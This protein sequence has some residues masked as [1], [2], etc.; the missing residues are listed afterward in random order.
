MK[1]HRGLYLGINKN[2]KPFKTDKL[3][4]AVPI[5]TASIV[6][7]LAITTPVNAATTDPNSTE[8]ESSETDT[9]NQV[10]D[11]SSMNAN[12]S[13]NA[14]ENTDDTSATPEDN[15]QTPITP[16]TTTLPTP[17]IHTNNQSDA[18][19]YAS[20]AAPKN[21]NIGSETTP[22][23]NAQDT[24]SQTPT[25]KPIDSIPPLGN[26]YV[27][28]SSQNKYVPYDS[29]GYASVL[30]YSSEHW[31]DS[32]NYNPNQELYSFYIVLPTGVTSTVADM[33][34]G[35]DQ[36]VKDLAARGYIQISSLTAFQLNNT[37]VETGNRE[38][39]YFRPDDNAH[40]LGTVD[41]SKGFIGQTKMS[42]KIHTPAADT[43]ITGVNIN[44]LED[45]GTTI[46]PSGSVPYNDVLY[47][48]IGDGTYDI[49]NGYTNI[50]SSYFGS[51]WLDKNVAGISVHN[52]A[53]HLDYTDLNVNDLYTVFT[54]GTAGDKETVIY[55][56][57]S[58]LNTGLAGSSYNIKDKVTADINANTKINEF[59]KNYWLPSLKYMG[60]DKTVTPSSTSLDWPGDVYLEPTSLVLSSNSA[61]TGKT[62][63]FWLDHIKTTLVPNDSTI[64]A[65]PDASFDPDNDVT[66]TAPGGNS[67]KISDMTGDS[68]KITTPGTYTYKDSENNILTVTSKVDPTKVGN[69]NVKYEYIDAQG[70]NY[71]S[72]GS[73]GRVSYLNTTVHVTNAK[74][75]GTDTTITKNTPW[76]VSDGVSVNDVNGNPLNPQ[77]TQ[78]AFSNTGTTNVITTKITKN[79]PDGTS[80]DETSIDTSTPGNY[81][82][83]YSYTDSNGGTV[84]SDPVTVIVDGS[85]ISATDESIYPNGDL[86]TAVTTLKNSNSDDVDPNTALKTGTLT[87][88][89]QNND[90]IDTSVP[91]TYTVTF[92]YTDPTSKK[93]VSSDPVTITI[94]NN[95]SALTTAPKTINTGSTWDPSQNI[96]ELKDTDGN[97]VVASDALGKTLTTTIT[98]S[99]GNP[100]DASTMTT[101]K[102]GTYTINYQYTDATGKTLTATS[103]LTVQN[104]TT[105]SNSGSTGSGANTDPNNNSGSNGSGTSTDP[106]NGS[107]G[108]S[109]AIDPNSNGNNPNTNS[110]SDNNQT[111]DESNNSGTSLVDNSSKVT[112]TATQESVTKPE[113]NSANT[114]N[115][116]KSN[117]VSISDPTPNKAGQFP[118]T[119]NQSAFWAS[120]LGMLLLAIGGMFGIRRK[121]E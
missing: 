42:V 115:T 32:N 1:Q 95:L 18:V 92:K 17:T 108:S 22:E 88:V 60:T 76:N 35:A 26:F 107:N 13:S 91:G 12:T 41:P 40:L 113:N 75:A 46:F 99:T 20:A 86:S 96:T 51:D 3:W 38:V 56:D 29:N 69:Y 64:V 5:A 85:Q 81:T 100:V 61:V 70:N 118:Q 2:S 28:V 7:G 25:A 90:P 53:A 74:I 114:T 36:Y 68:T 98:D 57:S 62:Y 83:V 52:G 37:S 31:M 102:T 44:A 97:P 55:P 65:D 109:T 16:K 27:N 103:I 49:N 72:N 15:N 80:T 79:N 10:I 112:N 110:G 6:A 104:P 105:G 39:F 4:L 11:N 23:S 54:T 111:T 48:G 116:V 101:P 8:P 19:S 71:F 30:P 50:P 78:T 93:V 43:G 117:S 120:G 87:A 106:D 9:S 47:A 58:P 45:D 73:T 33:Q 21:T 63:V 84:Q 82:V 77:D 94:K 14:D 59:K 67:I 34:A 119:G 121:K 24:V 89:D 66:I